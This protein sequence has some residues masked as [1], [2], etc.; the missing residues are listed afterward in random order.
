MSKPARMK[1]FE[2]RRIAQSTVVLAMICILSGCSAMRSVPSGPVVIKGD[3]LEA[4]REAIGDGDYQTA[5]AALNQ[6][7]AAS[8]ED[9]AV[10]FNLGW[11]YLYT[12]EPLKARAEL[13]KLER[14]KPDSAEYHHLRG[15]LYAKLDQHKDAVPEYRAALAKSPADFHLY[16]ELA[17]SLSSLNQDEQALDVL[18]E[19]FDH[20]PENDL[21]SQVDFTLASCSANSRLKHFGDAIEDCQQALDALNVR[22]KGLKAESATEKEKQRIRDMIS[23]MC[24][25]QGLDENGQPEKACGDQ[26]KVTDGEVQTELGEEPS[27]TTEQTSDPHPGG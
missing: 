26:P 4:A 24:L 25:I 20:I 19:G 15:A 23:N 7:L 1:A 2:T 3:P 22:D 13:D 17:N 27:D 8:P 10:H 21:D 12:N 18:G 5:Y 9:P 16:M 6:A 11:V 14:L